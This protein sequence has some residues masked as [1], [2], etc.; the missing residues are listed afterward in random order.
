MTRS[1]QG[2]TPYLVRQ[3]RI[4]DLCRWWIEI[5][6]KEWTECAGIRPLPAAVEPYL[7]WKPTGIQA[8]RDGRL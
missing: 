2:W 7:W 5:G 6:D 1:E 3:P 4:G 8:F